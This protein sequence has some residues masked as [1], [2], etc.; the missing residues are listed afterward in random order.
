MQIILFQYRTS[1]SI[2]FLLLFSFSLVINPASVSASDS[3]VEGYFWPIGFFHRFGKLPQSQKDIMLLEVEKKLASLRQSGRGLLV[4]G[5]LMDK[6]RTD[7]SELN[8][9]TILDQSGLVVMVRNFPNIYFGFQGPVSL[10]NRNTFFLLKNPKVDRVESVLRQVLTINGD[11]FA[12]S[13]SYIKTTVEG[14]QKALSG[15][16]PRSKYE[17]QDDQS[18][19]GKKSSK[20]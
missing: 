19:K 5:E 9:A 2:M 10:V 11:F 1:Y 8:P 12:F 18:S 20:R 3:S 17:S 7:A 13:Q 14:L 4:K 6:L 16:G 15:Q